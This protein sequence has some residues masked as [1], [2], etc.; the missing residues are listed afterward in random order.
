MLKQVTAVAGLFFLV[1]GCTQST[2][3]L[4]GNPS[5]M[6]S[7]MDNQWFKTIALANMTEIQSSQIALEK[8]PDQAVKDFAQHMIDDHNAAGSE[9][10]SL[11]ADK[12]VT[13]PTQ[14]DAQHAAILDDLRG[15]SGVDFE[16]AY[17]DLQVKAH[18]ETITAD[19]DEANNGN[20]M[21]VKAEAAKLL[22]TLKMH[23]SMARQLQTGDYGHKM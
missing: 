18:S 20:D 8:S 11:A 12:N 9:V 23:E 6:L 2:Q 13:L 7:D 19:G 10:A 17:M 22:P 5:P 3:E 21:Q 14:L 15:K 1:A 16:K 4:G